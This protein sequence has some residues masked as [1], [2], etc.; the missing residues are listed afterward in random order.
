MKKIIAI[1]LVALLAM[2][3]TGC[4]L[5]QEVTTTVDPEVSSSTVQFVA[6]DITKSAVDKFFKSSG[7]DVKARAFG[8]TNDEPAQSGEIEMDV[9][10]NLD[11]EAW[12]IGCHAVMSFVYKYDFEIFGMSEDSGEIKDRLSKDWDVNS[13]DDLVKAIHFVESSDSNDFAEIYDNISELSNS[14]YN[15][16]IAYLNSGDPELAV[17]AYMFPLTK[18]LGDKWGSKEIKAWDWFAAMNL[19]EFGYAAGY[20]TLD[21]TYSLMTPVIG[22]LKSTFSSWDESNDNF[23]DG[24]VWANCINPADS[25]SPYQSLVKLYGDLK[26]DGVFDSSVWN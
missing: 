18:E 17:A 12:A 13:K 25:S 3:V 15:E 16:L 1:L 23:L 20:L 10:K 7:N 26:A 4:S 5:F 24:L 22:K 9:D 8:F 19:A 2:S 6:S 14:E 11:Y 21:E